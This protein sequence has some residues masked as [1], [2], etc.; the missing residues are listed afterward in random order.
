MHE[1][2]GGSLFLLKE[3]PGQVVQFVS[4]VEHSSHFTLQTVNFE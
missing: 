1:Q 3:E 4:T 2:L